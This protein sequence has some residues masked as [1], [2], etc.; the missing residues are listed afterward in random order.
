MESKQKTNDINEYNDLFDELSIEW[1]LIT[2]LNEYLSGKTIFLISLY[3][4]HTKDRNE[5]LKAQ[6]VQTC[7][8]MYV[9]FGLCPMKIEKL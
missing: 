9:K 8:L 2:D 6:Y 5:R 7:F 4:E 3:M 1:Y